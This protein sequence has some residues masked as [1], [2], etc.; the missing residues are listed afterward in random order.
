MSM[1]KLT[2]RDDAGRPEVAPGEDLGSY[3]VARGLRVIALICGMPAI[4]VIFGIAGAAALVERLT[5]GK[6]PRRSRGWL[7]GAQSS[8]RVHLRLDPPCTIETQADQRI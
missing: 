8:P 7:L 5:T 2:E 6:Y 1:D 4:L 3:R